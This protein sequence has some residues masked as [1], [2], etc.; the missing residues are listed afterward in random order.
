MLPESVMFKSKFK[1]Y[2]CYTQKMHN[3]FLPP[4]S[5]F[6]VLNTENKMTV[7]KETHLNHKLMN[8]V[9]VVNLRFSKSF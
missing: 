9:P 7:P 8:L 1:A 2:L 4:L 5:M 3:S 6:I